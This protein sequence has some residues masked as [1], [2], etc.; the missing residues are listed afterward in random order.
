MLHHIGSQLVPES[1]TLTEVAVDG[2][3][4]IYTG[5]GTIPGF[6]QHGGQ[7]EH[8]LFTGLIV[9]AQM[10][11]TLLELKLQINRSTVKIIKFQT[12]ENLL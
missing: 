8:Q 12:P 11:G 4:V 6:G 7:H 3:Q 9:D 2:F 10:F 1:N 5:V